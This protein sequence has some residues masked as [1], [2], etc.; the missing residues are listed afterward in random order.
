MDI[1]AHVQAALRALGAEFE[2]LTIDPDL[3]DTAAFCAAYGFDLAESANAI[4]I[5][6]KRPPDRY[7]VCVALATSRLDVNH[8]VREVMGVKKLSFAPAELTREL[9]GMAIGGVTPFG[10]PSGMPVYVDQAV[11]QPE[12]IVVGG[13]DR[14]TK[15][16]ISPHVLN[17]V[18]NLEI[19]DGLAQPVL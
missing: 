8:R 9:T 14:A 16:V 11:M 7:A 19:V 10:L 15:I 12:R 3:A 17:Q 2:V 4:L 6:S 13:G 1:A 5:A 18:P